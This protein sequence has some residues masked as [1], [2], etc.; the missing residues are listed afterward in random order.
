MRR[1]VDQMGRRV[2]VP[3]RPERI[4]SLVPSQTE[5]LFDLGAGARVVGATRFCVRPAAPPERVKRVGGTKQ[6]RHESIDALAPDLVIGNKEENERAQIEALS[7]RHPVW[8]SDVGDLDDALDMIEAVGGLVGARDAATSLGRRIR[9]D[10][11]AL[12][13]AG[14]VRALY[15]IWRRPW[16]GVGGGTFID[17]LLMRAGLVNVVAEH[18]LDRYPELSD[19]LLRA[20]SPELVLLSSE[21]FPFARKHVPEIAAVLPAAR[22][23]L[24]DGEAF[25]WFGSRLIY[26]VRSLAALVTELRGVEGR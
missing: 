2:E 19:D 21:P 7:S 23:R 8:M 9:S 17:D 1:V 16:M 15:L 14:G 10:F 5:L 3:E 6:I 11:D 13:R 12:P 22:I 4:V 18:G 24:V 26:G 20:L 25:S